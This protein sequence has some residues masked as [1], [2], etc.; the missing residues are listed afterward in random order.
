M[1][2]YIYP[3]WP[4]PK[5]IRAAC[6]TRLG[7]VSEAPYDSFNVAHHVGDDQSAVEENRKL[8]RNDLELDEPYWINQTH[9]N[10]VTSTES[11]QSL[12]EADGVVT[13]QKNTPCVVMTADCLPILLCDATGSTVGALHG[14]WRGL[15]S[16]IIK[17]GVAAMNA[18]GSELLAWLGPAIGPTAF[19]VGQEVFGC[20]VEQDAALE[21]AFAPQ[22]NNKYLANIFHIAKIL[23]EKENVTQIYGGDI[24]NFSDER[25]YSYR[26]DQGQTGRMASLIWI[27]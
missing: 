19:E 23:L 10:I 26:R 24:C 8:L 21:K 16:G 22:T 4:A 13:A 2:E 17:N 7:G 6:T 20:F 1:R 27:L 11:N 14:G 12:P 9:S 3:D 5:N 25:F 15:A 18:P